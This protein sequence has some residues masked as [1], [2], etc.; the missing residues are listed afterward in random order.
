MIFMV[1]GVIGFVIAMVF[2]L[3]FG[4]CT[5]ELV[6][7][8]GSRFRCANCGKKLSRAAIYFPKGNK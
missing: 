2:P 1:F 4:D 7:H 3:V 6:F 5:H 8:E